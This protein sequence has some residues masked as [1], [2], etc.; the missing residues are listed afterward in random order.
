VAEGTLAQLD[1]LYFLDYAVFT[2]AVRQYASKTLEEAFRADPNP[3]RRRLHLLNLVKEEYAAYEDTGAILNAFLDYR[4]GKVE[5]P[6]ASLMTFRPGDVE[7]SAMF[8]SH[9]VASGDELYAALKLEEWIPDAWVDWF[10][11]LDLKKALRLACKFFFEDCAANQKRY[12]VIAYNKIKHGLM[13]V[14]SGRVYK[15][16]LPDSPAALFSTPAELKK[17]GTPAYTVY[18]FPIDDLG[19]E[20]RHA[21]IEFVQCDLRLF[22]GLYLACRY[23]TALTARGL[24]G[25]RELF[26]SREL[27]DVRHLIAEVT[28][29]K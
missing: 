13:V 7:L 26:D 8:D 23:P 28:A 1:P 10:P 11:Q 14:P 4:E 16:D 20:Q 3:L 21:S 22:A 15:G 27:F 17:Q 5:V 25:P 19:I 24:S 29:K 12:G 6:I 2:G 18:G 9:K